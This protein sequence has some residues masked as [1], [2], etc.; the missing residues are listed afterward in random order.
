M[1]FPGSAVV[2]NLPA[3]AGDTKD[4]GS[5]PGSGRSPG[6]VNSNHSSVLAWE[7]LW[8]E[9]PGGLQT[10]GSQRVRHNWETEDTQSPS[11]TS[12]LCQLCNSPKLIYNNM[13]TYW[14][15]LFSA[16]IPCICEL[17]PRVVELSCP[18]TCLRWRIT[19]SY[20]WLRNVAETCKICV[21]R[22]LCT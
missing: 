21:L 2:K 6:E 14:L 10:L 17:L 18:H 8:T 16:G 13:S 19:F 5:I 11:I 3:N 9:E 20:F 15:V 7:I 12:I 22:S 4:M 1:S